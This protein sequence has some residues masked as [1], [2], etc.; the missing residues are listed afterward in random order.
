MMVFGFAPGPGEMVLLAIVSILLFGK[1]LP[2]VAR[3]VGRGWMELKRG[4]SGIQSELNAAIYSDTPSSK[5]PP[6]RSY[7][8][9]IEDYE[10]QTAPKFEPPPAEPP[11]VKPPLAL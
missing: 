11:T 4:M 3:Q 9:E 6:S 1:R 7:A 10:E 5:S 8:N 2:D